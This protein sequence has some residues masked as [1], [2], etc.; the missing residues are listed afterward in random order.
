M[1]SASRSIP[2][3]DW[4]GLSIPP[5]CEAVLREVRGGLMLPPTVW[6]RRIRCQLRVGSCAADNTHSVC[7]LIDFSIDIAGFCFQPVQRLPRWVCSFDGL[8]QTAG[9][10]LGAMELGKAVPVLGALTLK[11]S[12]AG[13][14]HSNTLLLCGQPVLGMAQLSTNRIPLGL[15]LLL[16]HGQATL[17][18]LLRVECRFALVEATL[19]TAATQPDDAVDEATFVRVAAGGTS[20]QMDSCEPHAQATEGEPARTANSK[21]RR[22]TCE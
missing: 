9:P 21:T 8:A 19:I 7:D 2:L 3:R 20:G 18:G 16:F 6:E 14:L 1:P 15:H 12:D 4:L 13:L 22:A 17:L 10:L 11:C 5:E